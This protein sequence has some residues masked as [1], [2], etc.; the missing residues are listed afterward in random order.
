[1]DQ[2]VNDDNYFFPAIY[3][4]HL[5]TLNDFWY[6]R[7][8]INITLWLWLLSFQQ[9]YILEQ[10]LGILHSFNQTFYT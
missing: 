3:Q 2:T 9:K 8:E 1:M 7:V 10:P 4:N 5:S 6:Y